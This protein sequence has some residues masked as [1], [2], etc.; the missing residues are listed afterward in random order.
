M[1][2][3]SATLPP[4]ASDLEGWQRRALKRG[5]RRGRLL[6]GEL[7]Q[8]ASVNRVQALLLS[9]LAKRGAGKRQYTRGWVHPLSKEEFESELGEAT[10]PQKPRQF[11]ALARDLV[12]CCAPDK[13]L[14]SRNSDLAGLQVATRAKRERAQGAPDPTEPLPKRAAPE[15]RPVSASLE[16]RRELLVLLAESEAQEARKS[17]IAKA[18]PPLPRPELTLL[19]A[20]EYP[21]ANLGHSDP[22]VRQHLGDDELLVDPVFAA[23]VK[24]AHQGE[25]EE[26]R[27]QGPPRSVPLLQ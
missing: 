7:K 15:P 23:A 26:S 17:L 4:G 6:L 22:A 3:F 24:R 1:E 13:L 25:Q 8:P 9:A 5:V 19:R 2:F 27:E 21:E 10:P 12:A 11:A 18:I 16:R 14:Q 20:L